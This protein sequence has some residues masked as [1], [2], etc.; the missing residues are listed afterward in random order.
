MVI[1]Y[2]FF[3][4]LKI[5]QIITERMYKSVFTSVWMWQICCYLT[6]ERCSNT[7]KNVSV[8]FCS[9]AFVSFPA[10]SSLDYTKQKTFR[11]PTLKEGP[12]V[13]N[14]SLRHHQGDGEPSKKHFSSK[15]LRSI[16][17]K[18]AIILCEHQL[19]WTWGYEY[20][21]KAAN[22]TTFQRC[23]RYFLASAFTPWHSSPIDPPALFGRNFPCPS[24]RPA[25]GKYL[26]HPWSE[27]TSTSIFPPLS[28]SFPG[29]SHFLPLIP[30]KLSRRLLAFF[31][32]FVLSS[33]S[34]F[35]RKE[36]VACEIV[37]FF[38]R[39]ESQFVE[40]SER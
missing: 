39:V 34:Q 27:R 9:F 25:A 6:L 24:P 22:Y 17:A 12:G 29:L 26:R 7:L 14:W 1:I 40:G 4:S 11:L 5:S 30:S 35:V 38:R 36:T 18:P 23:Q 13:K 37:S 16:R 20:N 31:S 19:W 28:P 33:C 3:H 15:F 21:R 32:L 10:G 8:S 2:V